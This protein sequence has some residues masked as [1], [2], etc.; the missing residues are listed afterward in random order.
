MEAVNEVTLN[1]MREEVKAM[2]QKK[3]KQ[4][5]DKLKKGSEIEVVFGNFDFHGRKS[6]HSESNQRSSYRWCVKSRSH[7]SHQ[8]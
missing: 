1:L 5:Y 4:V 7:Y 6:D 8:S 3:A 2:D